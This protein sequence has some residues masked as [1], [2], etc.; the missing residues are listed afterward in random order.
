MDKKSKVIF[1]NSFKGGAGKTTLALMYCINHV[2]YQKGQYENVIYI[3][4]WTY[5]ERGPV[6]FSA[7]VV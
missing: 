3:W 7:R 4:I 2:F 1:V 5:W 6:I